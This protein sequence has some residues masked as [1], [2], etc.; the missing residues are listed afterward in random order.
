[1]LRQAREGRGPQEP[2]RGERVTQAWLGG[3][4]NQEP[5]AG[6]AVTS[7]TRFALRE[8]GGNCPSVTGPRRHLCCERPAWRPHSC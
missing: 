1:M 8:D 3:G 4:P 6:L 5:L 7:G 2:E